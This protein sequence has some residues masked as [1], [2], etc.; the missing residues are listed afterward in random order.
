MTSTS[1]LRRRSGGLQAAALNTVVVSPDNLRMFAESA[2]DK[3]II[4]KHDTI[5]DNSWVAVCSRQHK[6]AMQR[7]IGFRVSGLGFWVRC[8][9]GG[10]HGPRAVSLDERHSCPRKN[11]RIL[12]SGSLVPRRHPYRNPYRNPCSHTYITGF[13]VSIIREP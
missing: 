4:F 6:A 3:S 2:R 1:L 8:I 13:L 7:W 5:A 9:Q 10:L 11:N 12:S